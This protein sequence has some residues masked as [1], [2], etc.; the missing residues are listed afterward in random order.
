MSDRRGP[1]IRVKYKDK[2]ALFQAFMSFTKDGGIYL[3]IAQDLPA[4]NSHVFIIAELPDD[5]R[6]FPASGRV[7]WINNGRKKGIGVRLD[8]DIESQTLRNT[9]T[10]TI[11]GQLS[12]ASPTLTM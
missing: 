6:L 12:S 8:T 1:V 2:N 11:A 4:M 5:H 10:N 9:I 7:C 3:P